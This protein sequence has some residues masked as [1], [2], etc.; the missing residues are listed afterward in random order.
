MQ[1]V[2]CK[3][4]GAPLDPNQAD[5]GVVTCEYCGSKFTLSKSTNEKALALLAVGEH[6]L[7]TCK[8]D[9]AYA[10]FQKAAELD[11]QEAEAFFGMA[12]AEFKIQY[13]KDIVNNKLQPVCH[14]IT[15]KQFADNK[16]YLTA[17]SLGAEN[18][19][20]V[21][22]ARAKEIDYIRKE[23][24]KLRQSGLEYDC[25]ICVKVTD[26]GHKT[27]DS[28]RA[29]DI[30]YHLKDKGYR[31]FY[32]EREIQNETGADYEA[33]ILYALQCSPCM[34]VVCND[35][36]Y[37]NTAWVKNEY[38]R[39]ISLINDEQKETDSIAIGFYDKPIERLPGRAG[40]LQGVCLKNPDAYSKIVDFV[41]KH[42]H[43]SGNAPLINRKVYASVTYQKRAVVKSQIQKRTLAKYEQTELSVSEQAKLEIAKS[44]LESGNF[45][46]AVTRCKSILETN[47][48]CTMAHWYLFLAANNCTSALQFERSRGAVSKES[49]DSLEAVIAAGDEKQRQDCYTMLY[50]RT[51]ADRQFAL[52]EEYIS[53][54]DSTSKNVKELTALVYQDLLSDEYD[55]P[56]AVFD[57]LI[58]TV[59]DTDTYL[60]MTLGFADKVANSDQAY[61]LKCYQDVLQLDEGNGHA[62]WQTFR[63]N[64]KLLNQ[65]DVA[66]YLL[67][68]DNQS[69][70]EAE[71]F[72]YGFNAYAVEQM[73]GACLEK[74]HIAPQYNAVR[75]DF[76]FSL[77]PQSEKELYHKYL[78]KATNALL[79]NE[80]YAAASRYNDILIGEDKYNDAAYFKRLY[81]KHKTSSPFAFTADCD[82]LYDDLDFS[83]AIDAYAVTHA[84]QKN[85]YIDFINALRVLNRDGGD[86]RALNGVIITVSG[87]E[88]PLS[89][90]VTELVPEIVNIK[91]SL[92]NNGPYRTF[93]DVVQD[94]GYYIA[95]LGAVQ[96]AQDFFKLFATA[97]QISSAAA[98]YDATYGKGAYQKASR[99][100][101]SKLERERTL[102]AYDRKR[103]ENE[104]SEI[105]TALLSVIES[106]NAGKTPDYLAL[107]KVN[108]ATQWSYAENFCAI[109]LQKIKEKFG[110][111]EKFAKITKNA[112]G[113]VSAVFQLLKRFNR[114]EN[115]K[116]ASEGE[117]ARLV[118]GGAVTE[119]E[120][121]AFC[122]CGEL[123]SLQIPASVTAIGEEAFAG[124]I[125]LKSI[126]LSDSVKEIRKGAFE[127]CTQLTSVQ[128]GGVELIVER[129][130]AKCVS[131]KTV[132]IPDSVTQIGD[133]AFKACENLERLHM[134]SGVESIGGNALAG[135]P[136]LGIYLKDIKDWCK[137]NFVNSL[138][139]LMKM[140]RAL[141]EDR[142]F[143]TLYVGEKPLSDLVVSGGTNYIDALMFIKCE[144]L[145]SVS[146]SGVKQIGQWAFSECYQLTNATVGEGVT[147]LGASAFRGCSNLTSVSIGDSVQTIGDGALYLCFSLQKVTIPKRFKKE[148]LR[149]FGYDKRAVKRVKFTFT[150]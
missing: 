130:F 17:L 81:I 27:A 56:Y 69:K 54:P 10:A 11:A 148:L 18:Q 99:D 23:F 122:G 12:L 64:Q 35:E 109:L 16:N 70:V 74:C 61:A 37:L 67:F 96:L 9:D 131:L 124:C 142:M 39:F 21:Y 5:H 127:G 134:G 46:A 3:N 146:V 93:I 103:Y 15:D 128:M 50:N 22:T 48:S 144:S 118:V 31:P 60:D 95:P 113:N 58:K 4:C 77:I 32:S 137:L 25:F 66:V 120:K 41:E 36:S 65:F 52:Y 20:S 119:I 141:D 102:V 111:K 26:D 143:R 33:R 71:V 115:A 13:I 53:L 72:S 62:L 76:I 8:F 133:E 29:N 30:Y 79:S 73:L 38:L 145:K 84:G 51:K 140:Q 97:E 44:M 24:F 101:L 149:I 117:A 105:F 91:H 47:P 85:I 116:T 138:D 88:A 129:A 49:L 132:T 80:Q 63:I 19:R 2:T 90:A 82:S 83:A 14:G 89:K 135:C 98:Q 139:Q 136:K 40:R 147:F 114:T 34:L 150:R 108:L 78:N 87:L 112:V 43:L 68:K 75:L 107:S 121:R 110:T 6:A 125:H 94:S 59:D 100:A 126:E 55:D 45:E 92:H 1:A 57:T 42:Y 86:Y 123:E 28:E 106:A 7:D 104:S